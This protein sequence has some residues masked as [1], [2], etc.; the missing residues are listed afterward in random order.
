MTER[1]TK[2]EL[3]EVAQ[4]VKDCPDMVSNFPLVYALLEEFSAHYKKHPVLAVESVFLSLGSPLR[5]LAVPMGY[6]GSEFVATLRHSKDFLYPYGVSVFDSREHSVLSQYNL[7]QTTDSK[8]FINLGNAGVVHM[9][10]MGRPE[11]IVQS[12]N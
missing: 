5:L 4:V 6:V 1:F 12:L 3:S 8:N 10:Q 7:F 2:Q 11:R 9:R